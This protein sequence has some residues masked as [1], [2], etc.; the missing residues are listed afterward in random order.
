MPQKSKPIKTSS[1]N[2][3]PQKDTKMIVT[4]IGVVGTILVII[5]MLISNKV[6]S[7]TIGIGLGKVS[8]GR[9]SAK[10]YFITPSG[11]GAYV[12]HYADA[13]EY[14]ENS[15]C[16]GLQYSENPLTCLGITARIHQQVIVY[17]GAGKWH[18]CKAYNDSQGYRYYEKSEGACIE[19]GATME[20]FHYR[21]F[22]FHL[23]ASLNSTGQV[24]T[25]ILISVK[26]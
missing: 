22:A 9:T 23:D 2:P 3:E 13:K 25:M 4:T 17:A 1:M 24:N 11:F 15:A 6:K 20:L 10:L 14:I 26:P 16:T 12:S 7:Q 5:M 21:R 8:D 19:A 18:T